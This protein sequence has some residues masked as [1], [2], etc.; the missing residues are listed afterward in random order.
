M[1]ENKRKILDCVT[2]TS[3]KSI[4]VA[5][6]HHDAFT[7]RLAVLVDSESASA[8]EVFARVVQLERRAFVL[9]DRTSGMVMEANGFQHQAFVD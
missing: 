5:G 6:R 1:F 2:R 3:T 8:S 9:G 4:S 7:G